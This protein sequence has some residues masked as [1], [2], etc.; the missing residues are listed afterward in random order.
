MY[1]YPSSRLILFSKISQASVLL[2]DFIILF[3]EERCYVSGRLDG[4]AKYFYPSGSVET[5]IYENG[6]LEGKPNF[7]IPN[8]YTI[9]I[10]YRPILH[11][12]KLTLFWLIFRE[13]CET[14]YFRRMWGKRISKR[15]FRRRGDSNISWWKQRNK[16]VCGNGTALN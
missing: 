4:T 9:K 2:I 10:I 8:L 7:M 6:V 13:G 5:R 1:S 16:N 11:P 14:N 15:S 12:P 3:R